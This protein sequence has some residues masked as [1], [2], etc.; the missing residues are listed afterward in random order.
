MGTQAQARAVL[1]WLGAVFGVLCLI[2]L[3][4]AFAYGPEA[5]AAGTHLSD[6]GLTVTAC[7]GCP[8]CGL[9]RGFALWSVGQVGDAIALNPGVAV[10]YPSFWL[11]GIGGPAY[12]L[13][14][15]LRR[16]L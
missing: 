3:G 5:V 4:V 8:F 2:C 14:S 16:L 9:S 15:L 6:L 11:V 10:V 13:S 1:S 7:P 12:A